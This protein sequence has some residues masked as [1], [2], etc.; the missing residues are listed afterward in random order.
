MSQ[1]DLA[2]EEVEQLVSTLRYDGVIER[3]ASA[4]P[5]VREQTYRLARA[6]EAP[7]NHYTDMP[8]SSCPVF[9]ECGEGGVISPET[10]VYMD[11]WLTMF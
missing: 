9:V 2:A 1:V 5:G 3:C 7:T 8:C 11:E 4:T 10:C 6:A